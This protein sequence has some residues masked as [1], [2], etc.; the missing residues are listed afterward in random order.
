MTRSEAMAKSKKPRFTLAELRQK[1]L[2][3]A[4]EAAALGYFRSAKAATLL[5]IRGK[6]P[7]FIQTEYGARCYY[8]LADLDR[9]V[10]G[11]AWDPTLPP[12]G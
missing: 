3:T 6:G 5:R 10:G 8:R 4:E 2:L 11:N 12:A 9:W 7:V 1:A